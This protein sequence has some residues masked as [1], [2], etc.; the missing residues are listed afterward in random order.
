MESPV[1]DALRLVASDRHKLVILLGEFGAGKTA[2]LKGL[3]SKLNATY[4]N[5]NFLLTER[6]MT[7]PSRQC[8]VGVLSLIPIRRCRRTT[9]S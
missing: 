9:L 4:V 6:L 7:V 8:S 3:A 2:L 1:L 5:L